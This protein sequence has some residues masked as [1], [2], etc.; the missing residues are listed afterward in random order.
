MLAGRLTPPRVAALAVALACVCPAARAAAPPPLSNPVYGFPLPG[1]YAAAANA[2]SA[3]LA[4]ADRWLGS[5][6]YENPAARV[7]QGIELSPLFQRVSRQDLSSENRDF[8]QT[9]G[10]PDF[11][12]ASLSFRTKSWGLVLYAWQPVL[13]LEEQGYSAGPLVA[14]AAVQQQDHQRELRGGG[15]V[16]RGFGALRLGAS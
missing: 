11:A 8:E 1:D 16:S 15:A 14:P 6:A 4:L 13:R 12:G 7:P 2:T 3:G 10:F 9:S 5:S